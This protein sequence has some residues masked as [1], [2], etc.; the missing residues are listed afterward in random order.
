MTLNLQTFKMACAAA[1]VPK[2]PVEV[3]PVAHKTLKVKTSAEYRAV[4]QSFCPTGKLKEIHSLLIPQTLEGNTPGLPVLL[5]PTLPVNRPARSSIVNSFKKHFVAPQMD[6]A[7]FGSP[8]HWLESWSR[9]LLKTASDGPRWSGMPER[10]RGRAV[11][12][13]KDIKFFI[14]SHWWWIT[15]VCLFSTLMSQ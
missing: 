13:E 5:L 3:A 14:V 6:S 11:W 15:R 4:P 9:A 7:S 12:T 1:N 8:I 2:G 10:K